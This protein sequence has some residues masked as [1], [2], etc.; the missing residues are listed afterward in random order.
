MCLLCCWS[1]I[2]LLM[3]KCEFLSNITYISAES[4]QS[5]EAFITKTITGCKHEAENTWKTTILLIYLPHSAGR[6]RL[7]SPSPRFLMFNFNF[8]LLA[9]VNCYPPAQWTCSA[10]LTLKTWLWTPQRNTH[11]PICHTSL[12]SLHSA[13]SSSLSTP[14]LLPLFMY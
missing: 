3:Q 13:L 2:F 10:F 11:S 4:L 14:T 8:T 5:A 1:L 9:A 6:Q 7:P 12:S